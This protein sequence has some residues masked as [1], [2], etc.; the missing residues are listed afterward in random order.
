MNMNTDKQ[1]KDNIVPI[2]KEEK[3]HFRKRKRSKLY[4]TDPDKV[5]IYIQGLMIAVENG[6]I[7]LNTA[8]LLT[9][10]AEVILKSIIARESEQRQIELENRLADLEEKKGMNN[11]WQI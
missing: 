11:T 2:K 8:R 1:E 6:E 9:N 4:L 3:P 7:D 5:R 10:Q